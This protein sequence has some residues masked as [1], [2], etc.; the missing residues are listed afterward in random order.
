MVVQRAERV[1]GGAPVALGLAGAEDHQHLGAVER[2]QADR[3]AGA[4]AQRLERLDVLADPLGKLTAGQ[5]G[6]AEEQHRPVLV[7]LERAHEQVAVMGRVAQQL[8]THVARLERVAIRV[9][10]TLGNPDDH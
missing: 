1:Q 8:V 7:A 4:G 10:R 9:S 3:D 5:R 2:Q 6:V